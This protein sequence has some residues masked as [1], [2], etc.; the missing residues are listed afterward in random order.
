MIVFLKNDR[1][2]YFCEILDSPEEPSHSAG[3]AIYLHHFICAKNATFLARRWGG[4]SA[5]SV[6]GAFPPSRLGY[7]AGGWP[8]KSDAG[9]SLSCAG[10][11]SAGYWS[12]PHPI[13]LNAL[14]AMANSSSLFAWG[15]MGRAGVSTV[16]RC[17]LVS[18]VVVLIRMAARVTLT[19]S[20]IHLR[21]GLR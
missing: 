17:F 21:E 12:A 16:Q 4:R 20:R 19:C 9:A 5:D 10:G 6:S 3:W 7:R 14:A 13:F 18:P 1:K 15:S 11:W 8:Q 2:M